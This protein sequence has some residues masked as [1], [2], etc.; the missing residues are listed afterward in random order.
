[1]EVV[2]QEAQRE[3]QELMERTL[4][5]L[6][7]AM[8][9]ELADAK[10]D[11]DRR[12][13]ALRQREAEVLTET[14][15]STTAAS[16]APW[17]PT[18]M[19]SRVTSSYRQDGAAPGTASQLRALFESKAAKNQSTRLSSPRKE[20]VNDHHRLSFRA[21]EGML[22][23]R[24]SAQSASEERKM[25]PSSFAVTDVRSPRRPVL[26]PSQSRLLA[27]QSASCAETFDGCPSST[28]T[29]NA[30]AIRLP[31]ESTAPA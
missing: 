22:R 2:L 8:Q 21:Q 17:T 16:P 26:S 11:L 3:F 14:S 18:P 23:R 19:R 15:L 1:M 29:L 9:R 31:E 25:S 4:H 28:S 10:A 12:E 7:D 24:S 6:R 30:P 20:K 5:R 13:Q 27:T